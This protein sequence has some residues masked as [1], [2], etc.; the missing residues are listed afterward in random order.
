MIS[1]PGRRVKATEVS[2]KY[3]LGVPLSLPCSCSAHVFDWY[4]D[5]AA[6]ARAPW[7]GC[8]VI[9]IV[10]GLGPF[11]QPIG[12]MRVL[13]AAVRDVVRWLLRWQCGIRNAVVLKPW[14]RPCWNADSTLFSTAHRNHLETTHLGT[15][16]QRDQVPGAFIQA[17][18]AKRRRLGRELL[19]SEQIDAQPPRLIGSHLRIA[20][21]TQ[22]T[23]A[24][25]LRCSIVPPVTETPAHA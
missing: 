19:G 24:V 16:V 1:P 5:A 9:W 10:A 22:L 25:R 3:Q 18:N 17:T 13:A 11:D 14:F 2:E 7:H 21:A 20:T 23:P 8:V 12:G 15:T 4:D 6:Q